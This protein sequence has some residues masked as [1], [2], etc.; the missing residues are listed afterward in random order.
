MLERCT[1]SFAER[2]DMLLIGNF[3]DASLSERIAGMAAAAAGL[4]DRAD[5]HFETAGRQAREFPNRIDAPQVSYW[6]TKMLLDRG[7]PEDRDRAR[8]MLT[9][10]LDG[11]RA[12]GMPLHV[13]MAEALLTT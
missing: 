11:Y 8:A 6:H 9:D 7:V 3:F 4:W 13:D 10:A 1:R 12:Y 5:A 2:L